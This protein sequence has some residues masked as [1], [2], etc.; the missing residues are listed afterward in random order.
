MRLLFDRNRRLNR[1]RFFFFWGG[2][3]IGSVYLSAEFPTFISNN[4]KM[5]VCLFIPIINLI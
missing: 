1:G 3:G 4:C 2:G 5:C